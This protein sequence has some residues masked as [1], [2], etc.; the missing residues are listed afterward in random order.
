MS[1]NILAQSA[2]IQG[3]N[4]Y[5]LLN[6]PEAIQ[7]L[8]NH[9]SKKGTDNT[10][11]ILMLADSYY[12]T[13]DYSKARY[14]Y[15]IVFKSNSSLLSETDL[16]KFINSLRIIGDEKQADLIYVEYYGPTSERVKIY[17][18]QKMNLD[19]L[20]FSVE[21]IKSLGI[22]T[23]SGDLC[24]I[25]SKD[26]KT[27]FTSNRSNN[28]EIYPGNG[29]P[30]M[31]LYESTWNENSNELSNVKEIKT[32][33]DTKFNDA[34]LAFGEDNIIYISRN[35]INKKGKLEA[36][37]G[38]IS[39]LQILRGHLDNGVIKELKPLEF[40]SKKFNCSHPYVF[41]NGKSMVFSSD[42]PGGFGGPDLYYVEIFKDGSTSSPLN[43]GPRINTAGREVF[44][45]VSNDTLYYSSDGFFGFGGLDIYFSNISAI[46]SPSLPLNMGE[47]INSSKDDF[48]FIWTVNDEKA[49]FSSNRLGGKGDDDIYSVNIVTK[50]KTIDYNGFTTSTPE[51]VKLE[52]VK[53]IVRNEFNEII[54]ETKSA[55]DGS[56]NLQ[57]PN[58]S[59][60]S[61]TFSKPD[62]STEKIN[63]TTPKSA[64]EVELDAMLTSYKSITTKSEIAGLDQIKIDPIYFEYDEAAITEQ[65]E[66][67]LNKI[68]FAMEKFPLIIIKIESHT[69]ARGKDDYNLALSDRRAKSTR[70]YIIAKGIDPDRIV[71]AIGYGET[72]LLNKCTNGSKCSENEHGVNRRSNFIVISK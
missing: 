11:A 37:R 64:N 26:G 53:I 70:D 57:L 59:N 44:P 20:F 8:E 27:Y 17:N 35:F 10:A 69:D 43:L 31:S 55:S 33:T 51:G 36:G 3:T 2:L 38:E 48:H 46:K 4:H 9:V 72:R 45:T 60:L 29:R 50:N 39:N 61:I 40:N 6:Y 62:Y 24:A 68:V 54:A 13:M 21:N 66:V 1:Y 65:A 58:S 41:N 30:Y 15:N 42:M 34:T 7:Q 52:G 18:Y 14:N 25:K 28:K 63:I 67:E 16:I 5:N 22:N 19:S 56:Y 32:G 23:P 12:N 71:S 49:L 47:P